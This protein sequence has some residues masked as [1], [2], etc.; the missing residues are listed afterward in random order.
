MNRHP[1]P[2]LIAA[3]LLVS[4]VG[5]SLPL[6]AA[7][8]PDNPPP[9]MDAPLGGPSV[10]DREVPGVAPRFGDDAGGERRRMANRIPPKAMRQ[11]MTVIMDEDAPDD[12]RATPEQ[13]ERIQR[14][15]REFEQ[16]LKDYIEQ[17]RAELEELKA[18]VPQGAMAGPAGE[19]F[20]RLDDTGAPG[21]RA[22]DRRRPGGPDGGPEQGAGKARRAAE[23]IPVEVRERL[24]E[25]A[26]G[27]P[28]FDQVYTKIWSELRPEQQKAVDARLNEFR[29]RQAREREDD[30]VQKR[31][32]QKR[33][34]PGGQNPPPPR[35]RPAD[36]ARVGPGGAE[37]APPPPGAG[38]RGP[39]P[40]EPREGD[41]VGN[42][43]RRERFLRM[44]E[45]MTPQ[46]QEQLLS[47]LEA[48]ARDQG[49]RPQGQ[50]PMQR[51]PG[52]RPDRP[53]RGEPRPAPDM[54]DMPT[55][56]APSDSRD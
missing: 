55:P 46:E 52:K 53:Q 50:P 17:H 6:S 24:R 38:P 43:D 25:L 9:P 26:S 14:Y 56:S 33:G 21:S 13:R 2:R 10:R 7:A 37:M 28:Q 45:Q 54:Q 5:L 8:Q 31:L 18:K 1:S 35:R 44:F 39:S 22:G 27:A 20:R 30:Y 41:R 32:G 51:R 48:R 19:I 49:G 36:G 42:A 12:L 11:A 16:Q 34:E 23:D 40:R 29:D 47:R 4:V 15:G 3:S